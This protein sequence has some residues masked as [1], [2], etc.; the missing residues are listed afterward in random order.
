MYLHY[1]H[2]M[3]VYFQLFAAPCSL[4][5]YILIE[6]NFETD[7]KFREDIILVSLVNVI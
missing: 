6:G 2:A 7:P 5:L 1:P 4:K 3:A